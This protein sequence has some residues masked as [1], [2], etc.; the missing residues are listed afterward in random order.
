[1]TR[2]EELRK[3]AAS[4]KEQIKKLEAEAKK[5]EEES[6][7]KLGAVAADFLHDRISIDEL[8]IKALELGVIE[9]GAL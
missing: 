8:K 6:F 2:A 9:E 4:L 3:K 7:T 5:A 1:M